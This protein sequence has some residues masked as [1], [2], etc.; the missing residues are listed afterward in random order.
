MAI[1]FVELRINEYYG[2]IRK[3][4]YYV[5]ENDS[6]TAMDGFKSLDANLQKPVKTL[7]SKLAT[8]DGIF[9]S[10]NIRHSLRVIKTWPN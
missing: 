7:I 2:P 1:D 10:K 3:H 5:V 6:S 8:Y 9:H 4:V